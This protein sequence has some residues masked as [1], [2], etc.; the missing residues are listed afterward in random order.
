MKKYKFTRINKEDYNLNVYEELPL[1]R[2]RSPSEQ[3]FDALLK[4][5]FW[6][7]RA[8]SF[9]DP[10]DSSFV[11]DIGELSKYTENK[12]EKNVLLNYATEINL[13]T[14]NIKKISKAWVENT[15]WQNV[16]SMKHIALVACLSE[17]NNNEVMWAHYAQNGEG[18]CVEYYYIDIFN[19]KK[20]YCNDFKQ[21]SINIYSKSPELSFYYDLV[22]NIKYDDF[23]QYKLSKVIYSNDKYNFTA[24]NKKYIDMLSGLSEMNL[25]EMYQK[26][27]ELGMSENLKIKDR[28]SDT[29][30]FAK[31]KIWKYES[32][33]RF[34]LPSMPLEVALDSGKHKCVQYIKPRAIYIG[35]FA[36][37]TTRIAIY[38]YCF[39]N[40]VELYEMHSVLLNNSLKLK[41]KKIKE[42]KIAEFLGIKN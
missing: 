33:W 30:Y 18:F 28:A 41:P 4:N 23:S 38:A 21:Q 22:K 10:Y 25:S 19:I 35:E 34:I 42:R 3:N 29:I 27:I 32:E 5:E 6:M 26:S 40:K 36:K 7:S 20:R 15:Y 9:N 39:N 24:F 1:F 11:V 13:K 31:N 2:Y 8:D 16:N 14:K 37:L 17:K 12:I